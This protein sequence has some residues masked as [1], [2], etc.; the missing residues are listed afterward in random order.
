[1]ITARLLVDFQNRQLEVVLDK[2]RFTIGRS[3]QCD[4]VIDHPGVGSEHAHI[5]CTEHEIYFE[6]LGSLNGS[7]VN[8][9]P[10]R[11]HFLLDGDVIE[12]AKCRLRYEPRPADSGAVAAA[13]TQTATRGLRRAETA[14]RAE[15]A[16]IRVI[17]GAHAGK[18]YPLIKSLTTIGRP[19][20]QVAAIARGA[21]GY[22]IVHV[23]GD[24]LMVNGKSIGTAVLPLAHLDI[25]EFRDAK[26]RFME[27]GTR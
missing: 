6:D 16:C 9:Q 14:P 18:T 25:I 27:G 22:S 20:I 2:E 4:L 11:R 8:G 26:V 17:E 7:R 21:D 23:D 1:M 24:S 12:I 13:S 5:V 15:F 19:D 3:P 10:V